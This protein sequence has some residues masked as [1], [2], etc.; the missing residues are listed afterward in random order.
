[1]TGERQPDDHE[2][3]AIN[4]RQDHKAT[5]YDGDDSPFP[6]VRAAVSPVDDPFLPVNTV[7]FWAIGIIFT[8]VSASHSSIHRHPPIFPTWYFDQSMMLVFRM[9]LCRSST[10]PVRLGAD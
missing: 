3:D 10:D 5:S 1:V 2:V 6:E 9:V 8:I 4:D 7:R